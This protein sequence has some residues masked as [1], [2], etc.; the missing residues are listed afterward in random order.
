LGAA[1]IHEDP[2]G[3]SS[4]QPAATKGLL[5]ALTGMLLRPLHRF[6]WADPGRR[7]RKL[8]QFG[9]VEASGGRDLV[10]A[11]ELTADPV[12]RAR[13]LRHARDEAR[14]ATMFQA[15][16]RSLRSTLDEGGS[17]RAFSEWFAPGERGIEGFDV[18]RESDADLLAFLHLSESAAARDFARYANVL[19]RDAATRTLFQHVL[20]D[21]DQHMRYTR[22]ELIRI[23]PE[24]TRRLLWWAR[25]RRL[26]KAYLRFAMA[27]TGLIAGAVLTLQYFLLL[28]PFA[29]LAK[30]AARRERPGWVSTIEGR[31]R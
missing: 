21:E 2:P 24:R 18:A 7:A 5:Q 1:S 8:L 6:I 26:W 23:A 19:H 15:R 27:L 14:H 3:R 28:P 31:G 22:E 17:G 13:F 4:A 10:R 9:E 12:L 29:W 25:M 30:R 16:G 20:R 11:A